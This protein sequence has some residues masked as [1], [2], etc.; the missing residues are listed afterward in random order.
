[1]KVKTN[2]KAGITVH[3]ETNVSSTTTAGTVVDVDI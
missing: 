2:V 3:V 1:M